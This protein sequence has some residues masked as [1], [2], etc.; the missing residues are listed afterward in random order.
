M[1]FAVNDV[2]MN[3]SQTAL[4]RNVHDT[5]QFQNIIF[6][7]RIIFALIEQQNSQ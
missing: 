2:S 5:V 6:A 7:T 4:Y 3:D 1:E